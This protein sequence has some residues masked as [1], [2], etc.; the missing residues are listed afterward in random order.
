[1][2][3][4]G[5]NTDSAVPIRASGTSDVCDAEPIARA[6]SDPQAFGRLYEAHYSRILNYLYRRTLNVAVAEALTSNTFF[7]ALRGL[8]KYRSGGSLEG[9]LYRIASNEVKMHWRSQRNRRENDPR[10]REELRRVAFASRGEETADGLE[11][12]MRR[13]ASLHAAL[14]RLPERYQTVLV[15]RYFEGLTYGEIASALRKRLGTVK[16]LIHRG[17]KRLKD[18]LETEDAT[19]CED[20]H[21]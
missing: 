18:S 15:L 17:L 16:S 14:R 19:F 4:A 10:W 7:K 11:E 2:Q 6:K 3:A 1:M 9:W 20:L 5:A 12:K 13:F 21:L 8:P